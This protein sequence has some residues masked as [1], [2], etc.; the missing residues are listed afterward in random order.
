MADANIEVD[1]IIQNVSKDGKTDFSFTVPH[2]DL[3]RTMELLKDKVVPELGAADVVGDPETK[4]FAEQRN[5]Q[6]LAAK[7]A[8]AEGRPS[9]QPVRSTITSGDSPS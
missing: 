3:A 8:K 9:P 6:K 5:R 2:P 1:V 7:K 4:A